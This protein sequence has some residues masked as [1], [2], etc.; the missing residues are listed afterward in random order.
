MWSHLVLG[1]CK[2][3]LRNKLLLILIFTHL[4]TFEKAFADLDFDL[5]THSRV[6]THLYISSHILHTRSHIFL[7]PYLC[8]SSHFFTHLSYS[9]THL[10]TYL[11]TFTRLSHTLTRLFTLSHVFHTTSHV[12]LH[13]HTSF[14]HPHTSFYTFTHRSHNLTRLLLHLHTSS[15]IFTH[16]HTSL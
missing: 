10:L 5:Y 16:L 1:L 11:H 6:L 12:F 4:Q 3:P 7:G 8:T 9:L 14:T 2:I 13:L 15:H